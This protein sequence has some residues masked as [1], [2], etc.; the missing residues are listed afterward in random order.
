[1]FENLK[2]TIDNI[3]GKVGG[4]SENETITLDVI[5]AGS[6]DPETTGDFSLRD[7][8]DLWGVQFDG[9]TLKKRSERKQKFLDGD[10]GA[11]VDES[12]WDGSGNWWDDDAIDLFRSFYRLPSPAVYVDC[13]GRKVHFKNFKGE[14]E[15]DFLCGLTVK[16][17]SILC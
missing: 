8:R 9:E 15:Y 4:L 1:M 7:F 12:K 6:M 16:S 10:L 2:N 5:I 3:R 13:S 11:L 14:P 17:M